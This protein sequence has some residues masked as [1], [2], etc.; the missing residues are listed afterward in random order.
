MEAML[1]LE[2]HQVRVAAHGATAINDLKSDP[3]DVVLL[4]IGLPDLDGYE[5]ARRV[6]QLAGGRIKLIALTGYGQA[7]DQRRAYEA[8][9]DFHLTKPVALD[10]LREIL[11]K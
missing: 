2:G 7:E 4:D 6:R 1:S 5:V 9:F 8:G 3:A 11:S 10:K